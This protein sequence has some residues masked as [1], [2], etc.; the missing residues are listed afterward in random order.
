[1][2]F[3]VSGLPSQEPTGRFKLEPVKLFYKESLYYFPSTMASWKGNTLTSIQR[4]G[5]L[6]YTLGM[7]SDNGH[8]YPGGYSFSRNWATR[9]EY[10]A[11]DGYVHLRLPIT[12]K[13]KGKALILGVASHF[14][15]FHVDLLDRIADRSLDEYDWIVIDEP[16]RDFSEWLFFFGLNIPNRKLLSPAKNQIFWFDSLDCFAGRSIKPYWSPETL[17][18]VGSRS[19]RDF[20]VKP[21]DALFVTRQ[22]ASTRR[23]LN[24]RDLQSQLPEFRFMDMAIPDIH[25]QV[26]AFSEAK[27]VVGPIGSDLFN[28]IHCRPG[29]LVICIV[30]VRYLSAFGDNAVMIQSLAESRGL[31]LAFLAVDGIG[32]NPYTSNYMVEYKEI[33]DIVNIISPF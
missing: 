23:I 6:G 21:R 16:H 25:E 5:V 8:L 26:L 20:T 1:M 19:I 33:E 4:G 9:G 30:D 12:K 18:L 31:V 28:L 15:H 11:K 10:F 3:K 24:H 17:K 32:T 13:F 27:V 22:S 29:T 14:G 7:V 2:K